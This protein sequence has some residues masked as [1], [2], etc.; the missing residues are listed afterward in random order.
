MKNNKKGMT[1]VECIIA[2]AVF[3]VATT[4]FTMAATA[5]VNAQVKS[6]RRNKIANTQTTNLEH[7]SNYNQ[8]I[9]PTALNVK[10]MP[11]KY[12]VSFKFGSITVLNK[13]VYGYDSLTDPDDKTFQLSFISPIEQVTVQPGEWWITIYNDTNVDYWF[14]LDAESGFEFFDN[15]K[16]PTGTKSETRVYPANGGMR[17]LGVKSDGTVDRNSPCIKVVETAPGGHTYGPYSLDHFVTEANPEGNAGYC[18]FYF[19]GSGFLNKEEYE[20]AHPTS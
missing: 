6:H 20:N 16:N 3:A 7:F 15:E 8:L 19:D 9:D 4:G 13:D 5:C 10:Q 14:E 1:L 2:M 18:S 17:K 11:E 12:A